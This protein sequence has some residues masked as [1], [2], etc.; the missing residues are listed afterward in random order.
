ML[1]IDVFWLFHY[2][3]P[4]EK[5]VAIHLNKSE[6]YSPKDDLHQVEMK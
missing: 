3:L 2:Y 5:C 1:S 6:S 4:F